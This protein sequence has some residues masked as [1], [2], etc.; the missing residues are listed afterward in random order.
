M[1]AID[2]IGFFLAT[3]P[4]LASLQIYADY[5]GKVYLMLSSVE[6]YMP[7]GVSIGWSGFETLRH[8]SLEEAIEFDDYSGCQK[9]SLRLFLKNIK[10]NGHP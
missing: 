1:S 7:I 3:L 2:D 9:D 4:G 5:Q 8:I 6:S 10:L